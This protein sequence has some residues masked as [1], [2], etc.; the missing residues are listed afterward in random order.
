MKKITNK[1]NQATLL[2]ALFFIV[3]FAF[4][5]G[6]NKPRDYDKIKESGVLRVVMNYGTSDYFQDG[7]SIGGKQYEMVMSLSGY[8]DIP[9]EIHLETGLNASLEGLTGGKYDLVARF[10][11][12][13][14]GL[15]E[16]VAFTESIVLDKQVLVQRKAAD[17]TSVF[18]H[19]QLELP[20][21]KI[22]IAQASPYIPRL[23]NLASEI[24]DTLQII[25]M[26]DYESAH[27]LVLVAKGEIDYAVC[28]YQTASSMLTDYPVLDISTGISFSQLHAWAVSKESPRLLDSI[29]GWIEKRNV[30]STFYIDNAQ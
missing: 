27:L 28:D 25:E 26:Q 1:Y 11:P 10:I 2:S 24:G 18:V 3:I 4:R 15:R 16:L 23:K 13:T 22:Y 30:K 12:V 5:C 9:V 20:G 21:K 6:T 8:L 14:S 7:D 19:S 17:T 29:N